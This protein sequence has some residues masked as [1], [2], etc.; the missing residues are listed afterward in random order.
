MIAGQDTAADP[1]AIRQDVTD[2]LRRADTAFGLPGNNTSYTYSAAGTIPPDNPQG[3]GGGPPRQLL[4]A[5]TAGHQTVAVLTGAASVTASSAGSWLWEVP[6][7]DPVNAFDG[8]PATA[9]T[10]AS[11]VSAAGQWVQ[12]NF[13]SPRDLSGPARIRL[14]D[15]IPRPVATRLV[16]TTAAGR[17]VTTTRVTAAAQPL[18]IP[19]GTTGWLRITIAAARGGTAG[20]PG[21]GISDVIIPGVRVTSYLRARPG[22]GRARPRRSASTATPAPRSACPGLRPRR[23]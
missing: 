22:S 7:A 21:A 23:T 3:A 5:G 11:P 16:V 18:R 1:P 12:I 10:E 19:Q 4:P 13:S 14:L 17:A 20:G 2:G 8:N 6:Q 9:W 15:D